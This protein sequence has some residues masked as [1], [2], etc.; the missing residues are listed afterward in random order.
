MAGWWRKKSAPE[1]DVPMTGA[2]EFSAGI[3]TGEALGQQ[4]HPQP[5]AP[6]VAVD[7]QE[8]QV[9]ARL[10]GVRRLQLVV[11]RHDGL[12]RLR[13]GSYGFRCPRCGYFSFSS[14]ST[15]ASG[16]VPALTTS[17]SP[18]AGRW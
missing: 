17:C 5:F 11:D 9:K 2:P 18:P 1:K 15:K 8:G 6:V 12:G 4:A 10:T 14:I 7:G 13:S 16:E 3:D